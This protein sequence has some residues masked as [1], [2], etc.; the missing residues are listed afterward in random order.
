VCV[1][2]FVFFFSLFAFRVLMC[3][4]CTCKQTATDIDRPKNAGAVCDCCSRGV[5]SSRS[6]HKVSSIARRT[7]PSTFECQSL[8][9]VWSVWCASRRS[10]I[11][12]L[13]W[14]KKPPT[15]SPLLRSDLWSSSGVFY[16]FPHVR[17]LCS[18]ELFRAVVVLSAVCVLCVCVLCV[19]CVC[20][21]MVWKRTPSTQV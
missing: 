19:V 7:V 14:C 20:S 12:T 11:H 16:V 2:F 1:C 6:P 15:N 4:S 13:A 3:S 8:V 9:E 18:S 21:L 17:I 10:L 5:R